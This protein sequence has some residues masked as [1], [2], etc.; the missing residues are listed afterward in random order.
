MRIV[1]PSQP[2]DAKCGA[3]LAALSYPEMHPDRM[4]IVSSLLPAPGG[5]DGS[6]GNLLKL[7]LATRAHHLGIVACSTLSVIGENLWLTSCVR[8]TP[9]VSLAT[10]TGKQQDRDDVRQAA[11][12]AGSPVP[13]GYC[14]Q[15]PNICLV[16]IRSTSLRQRLFSRSIV[17]TTRPDYPL[18][19]CSTRRLSS[20]PM[21]GQ[22]SHQLTA[23]TLLFS[24]LREKYYASSS[25]VQ[26]ASR[27]NNILSEYS[28]QR[29]RE[30]YACGQFM[31]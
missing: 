13:S 7:L 25:H 26:L 18:A 4:V 2:R 23:C 11:L 5:R 10:I 20:G 16:F 28:P 3:V 19:T 8:E 31:I 27:K 6:Q 14:G 30:A 22:V 24:V 1:K 29:N 15:K 17:I 21:Q 9:V 12:T